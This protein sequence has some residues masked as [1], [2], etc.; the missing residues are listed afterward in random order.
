[1]LARPINT[2]LAALSL[3]TTCVCANSKRINPG[4]R[5][6][7][8]EDMW[9]KVPIACGPSDLGI[10]LCEGCL[11]QPL[12][13]W[14]SKGAIHSNL[15]L[16]NQS[17]LHGAAHPAIILPRDATPLRDGFKFAIGLF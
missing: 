4:G 6:E 1:M 17:D 5:G 16:V 14:P 8:V 10:K 7:A 12:D 13:S 2:S 9:G 15:A 3:Q 11:N